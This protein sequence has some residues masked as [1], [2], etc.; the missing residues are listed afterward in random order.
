[1]TGHAHI[2]WTDLL[3]WKFS[4]PISKLEF[5]KIFHTTISSQFNSY[6]PGKCEWNF[7]YIIFKHISVIDGWGISCEIA[8]IRMSLDFADDQSTLVQVMAWCRQAT[9]HYLSQCWPRSMSKYGVIHT[10]TTE[11]QYGSYLREKKSCM[12]YFSLEILI[13]KT[14]T[15]TQNH[16]LKVWHKICTMIFA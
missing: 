13:L 4:L 12:F 16:C 11:G 7:R 1:M 3:L 5:I 8:L 6:A 14:Q 10:H 9:S 2:M 15:N